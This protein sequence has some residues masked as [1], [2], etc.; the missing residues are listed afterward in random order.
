MQH[1]IELAVLALLVFLQLR[2]YR[3]ASKIFDVFQ[4]IF[5]NASYRA[6]ETRCMGRFINWSSDGLR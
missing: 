3:Q 5:R 6:E 4:N 2:Y 1:I